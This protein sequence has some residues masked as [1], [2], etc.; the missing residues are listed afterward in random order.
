MR[1]N[2]LLLSPD[3]TLGHEKELKPNRFGG[4]TMQVYPHRL[5]SAFPE[6]ERL[7][8]WASGLELMRKPGA[9]MIQPA[10]DRPSSLVFDF[11]TELHGILSLEVE[12]P[13]LCN[14]TATFGEILHEV[15]GVVIGSLYPVQTEF[16][17]IPAKG[18]HRRR[19][20][21][22]HFVDHEAGDGRRG[23]RFVALRLHDLSEPLELFDIHA[24]ADFTFRQR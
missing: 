20:D 21:K 24:D 5:V 13:C 4:W 22:L 7:H 18:R 16:W 11:G 8:S 2:P 1:L 9:L 6:S 17:H 23:F 10:R 19:F 15:D 14:I 3:P 12:T